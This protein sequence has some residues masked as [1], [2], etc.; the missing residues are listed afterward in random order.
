MQE[1]VADAKSTAV[2]VAEAA[3]QKF[4]EVAEA[5][6]QKPVKFLNWRSKN[7]AK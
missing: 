5:A 3:Q 7:S 6:Q 1:K 2:E 4:N